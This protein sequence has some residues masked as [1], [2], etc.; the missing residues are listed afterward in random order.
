[1]PKID[2]RIEAL[3]A[4]LGSKKRV[5]GLNWTYPNTKHLI[6]K[7]S[8]LRHCQWIITIQI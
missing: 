2:E 8:A 4:K 5:Y 7:R 6:G 3:E 1:M